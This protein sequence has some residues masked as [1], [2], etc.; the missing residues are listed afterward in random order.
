VTTPDH[1]HIL[2]GLLAAAQLVVS[3]DEEATFVRDYRLIRESADSLYLPEL[4]FDEP[5]VR[6]NPLDFYPE[7]ALA[8]A[9]ATGAER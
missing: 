4:E 5:A 7:G 1:A 3:A 9:P 8:A 6:F 2:T